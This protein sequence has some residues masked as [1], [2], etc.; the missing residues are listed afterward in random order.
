MGDALATRPARPFRDVSA[1]PRLGIVISMFPELHETFILRALGQLVRDGLDATLDLV[2][3]G[4]ERGALE[5][6]AARAGLA[7][8]ARFRGAPAR[9]PGSAGR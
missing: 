2:G 7:G 8:R 9:R 3:I 1:P 6:L 5:T 4:P